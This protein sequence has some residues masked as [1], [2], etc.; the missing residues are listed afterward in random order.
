MILF[1]FNDGIV[2]ALILDELPTTWCDN[3]TIKDKEIPYLFLDSERISTKP[4]GHEISLKLGL[5]TS[6]KLAKLNQSELFYTKSKDLKN[7]FTLKI[8]LTND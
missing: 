6:F 8:P 5:N 4:T 3:K 7:I 2:S 1:N